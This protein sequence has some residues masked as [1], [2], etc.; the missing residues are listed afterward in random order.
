MAHRVGKRFGRARPAVVRLSTRLPHRHPRLR[1]RDPHHRQSFRLADLVCLDGRPDGSRRHGERVRHRTSAREAGLRVEERVGAAVDTA[2]L[3]RRG[4]RSVPGV[5]PR[6]RMARAFDA[7]DDQLLSAAGVRDG[8]DGEPLL[9][10]PRSLEGRRRY[11]TR[12]D[13]PRRHVVRNRRRG[14]QRRALRLHEN[15]YLRRDPEDPRDRQFCD[16]GLRGARSTRIRRRHRRRQLR[17]RLRRRGAR[18]LHVES[19]QPRLHGDAVRAPQLGLH[20]RRQICQR[21]FRVD[22]RAA[23]GWPAAARGV[24]A[25]FHRR[26]PPRLSG[27]RPL[28][29]SRTCHACPQ[30][31]LAERRAEPGGVNSRTFVR[32]VG[33]S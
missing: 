2:W 5:L 22:G 8:T 32:R 26:R 31:P 13:R 10:R 30:Q 23:V 20:L 11:G 18:N 33:R 17:H 27:A 9:S 29:R 28:H 25:L 21:V 16:D 6:V 14:F 19:D 7:D 12:L 15:P 3:L 4:D 1:S 24:R